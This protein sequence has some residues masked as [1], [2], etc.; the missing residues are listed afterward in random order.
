MGTSLGISHTLC[1]TQASPEERET[2]INETIA[3]QVQRELKLQGVLDFGN[4][5]IRVIGGP[6]WVAVH[7]PASK[8]DQRAFVGNRPGY[9][10]RIELSEPVSGPILLGHSSHFGLGLF[11]PPRCLNRLNPGRRRQ[12][13]RRIL[14]DADIPEKHR[15]PAGVMRSPYSSPRRQRILGHGTDAFANRFG[16]RQLGVL[17]PDLVT[18]RWCR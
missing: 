9:R 14:A 12:I 1:P 11:A 16:R 5:A 18:G 2:T 13:D 6:V 4:S 10:V 8:R 15:R 17:S 7:I 3:A